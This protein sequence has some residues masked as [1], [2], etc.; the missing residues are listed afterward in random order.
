MR[1]AKKRWE[2]DEIINIFMSSYKNII[3]T[4]EN[5]NKIL[6]QTD[7]IK[8]WD[9]N[10]EDSESKRPKGAW[11]KR[12]SS[13]VIFLYPGEG[14]KPISGFALKPSVKLLPEDINFARAFSKVFNQDLSLCGD[15]SKTDEIWSALR[16]TQFLRAISRFTHFRS[17]SVSRWIRTMERSMFLTYEGKTVKH[18]ILLP[19]SFEQTLNKLQ[20]SY[21]KLRKSLTIEQALLEEKWIRAVVDG[22]RVALLASK[23]SSGTIN[24]F[25]SLPEIKVKK[26]INSYAPHESLEDLQSVLEKNDMAFV[27]TS[28]GDILIL[29]GT[30]IVFNKTQGKWRY[31]NYSH[32]H[33]ILADFVEEKVINSIISMV[34]NLSF[35]RKGALIVILKVKQNLKFLVS[36]YARD[37]QANQYL[38]KALKG[39]DV[40]NRSEK[41]IITAASTID[42]A[43]IFDQLGK[44]LDVACMIGKVN[45]EQMKKLN[46]ADQKVFPGSRTNAAWKSS[47]FGIAIKISSDGEISVFSEGKILWEIG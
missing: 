14:L 45:D 24:G 21:I 32:F 10:Q 9:R 34:L 42:G 36:D 13:L 38:R 22:H 8:I 16:I 20:D 1:I 23:K 4:H 17:L 19:Y 6:S 41:Q 37:I 35:E 15:I 33:Q 28:S 5:K 27:A 31:L 25:I 3:P 7:I 12:T 26:N 11:D 44:V 40:S 18:I 2:L 43:I 47:L 30:G 46:I 29:L 39:L